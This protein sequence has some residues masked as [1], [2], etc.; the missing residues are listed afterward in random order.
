QIPDHFSLIALQ[1]DHTFVSSPHSQMEIS[2]FSIKNTD[3]GQSVCQKLIATI[4][5]KELSTNCLADKLAINHLA[6]VSQP[7]E[8]KAAKITVV[9]S[10]NIDTYLNTPEIP[11]TGKTILLSNVAT[12][13]GGKG[14]NQAIGVAKLGKRVTLI[15]KVG[16]DLESD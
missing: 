16:K 2:S 15:G 4:E 9:G 8:L 5:Q 7:Y 11:A 14:L 1:N 6:T 13:P 12:L 3:F 10:I